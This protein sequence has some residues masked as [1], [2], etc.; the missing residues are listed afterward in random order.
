MLEIDSTYQHQYDV[1]DINFLTGFANVLAESVA[2]A[3]RLKALRDALEA[4][5]L[6]AQEL[7]HRVRNNLQIVTGMLD[8]YARNTAGRAARDGI[9]PIVRRVNT[10]AQLHDSLLNAG[11]SGTVDL[12][13]YLR[14][15]C[16]AAAARPPGNARHL[17]Q[18]GAEAGAALHPRA[19]RP[20][21]VWR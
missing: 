2:A 20:A 12:A 4:K 18:G 13:G 5:D 7:H 1:H 19:D 10:L 21:R 3:T 15:L 9:G 16:V 8:T 14:A 11:L 17:A 6:L